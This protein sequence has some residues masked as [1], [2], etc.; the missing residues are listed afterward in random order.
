M[1][2]RTRDIIKVCLGILLAA[3]GFL[4]LRRPSEAQGILAVLPFVCIGVGC[5]L[6]GHGAGDL[7]SLRALKGAPEIQKQ[8]EIE[9]NDERNVTLANLAKGKAF[10]IMLY[11]NGALMVSFVLMQAETAVILLLRGLPLCCWDASSTT[12]SS[13]KGRCEPCPALRLDSASPSAY[14]DRERSILSRRHAL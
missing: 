8:L 6:F 1:K 7:L 11:L 4:L 10:D 13:T 5:G 9:Q 12:G 3:A 2:Q 14:T